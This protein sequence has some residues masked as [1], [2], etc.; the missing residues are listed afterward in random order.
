MKFVEH[1]LYIAAAMNRPGQDGMWDEED[2]FYYDLLRLPDG[3]ATRL[4]VRSMV[5]L[6]AAYA[7]TTVDRDM[8][9]R[10][11]PAA[12][13]QLSERSAPDARAL[14]RA[15]IRPARG[16][17]AWRARDHRPGQPASGCGGFSR[18]CSMRTNF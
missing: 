2:G 5:G 10:A 6:A 16:T 12:M 7:P 13:A 8:A 11:I 14:G 4:K 1:F 3:S 17:W 9:A 18:R 15:F